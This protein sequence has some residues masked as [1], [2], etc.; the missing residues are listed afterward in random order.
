VTHI[1]HE[2]WSILLALLFSGLTFWTKFFVAKSINEVSYL[3]GGIDFSSALLASY[4]SLTAAYLA[5]NGSDLK[6]GIVVLGVSL[7]VFVMSVVFS[8]YID[9]FKLAVAGN[10]SA[11]RKISGMMG[12]SYAFTI[13]LG[14]YLISLYGALP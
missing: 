7:A 14:G 9:Q 11:A 5:L 6:V 8:R 13:A 3:T 4:C 2:Y 10:K 12:I 1:I